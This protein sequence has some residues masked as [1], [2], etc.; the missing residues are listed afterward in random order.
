[1]PLHTHLHLPSTAQREGEGKEEGREA[2]WGRGNASATTYHKHTPHTTSPTHHLIHHPP[3][4]CDFSAGGHVSIHANMLLG[5]RGCLTHHYLGDKLLVQMYIALSFFFFGNFSSFSSLSLSHFFFLGA[6]GVFLEGVRCRCVSYLPSTSLPLIVVSISA[7]LQHAS[8]PPFLPGQFPTASTP[9]FGAPFL[10][11]DLISSFFGFQIQ[12][13]WGKGSSLFL[14]LCL[15]VYPLFHAT[16]HLCTWEVSLPP[17]PDFPVRHLESNPTVPSLGGKHCFP[18]LPHLSQTLPGCA[19]K[20][21]PCRLTHLPPQRSGRIVLHHVSLTHM[22]CTCCLLEASAGVQDLTLPPRQASLVGCCASFPDSDT[23]HLPP[24]PGCLNPRLPLPATRTAPPL[25]YLLTTE[26][27]REIISTPTFLHARARPTLPFFTARAHTHTTYPKPCVCD[28]YLEKREERFPRS[29]PTVNSLPTPHPTPPC[30]LPYLWQLA[31]LV[32]W[33][34][35]YIHPHC[36]PCWDFLAPPSFP[37]CS[38][39]LVQTVW[40][41]QFTTHKKGGGSRPLFSQAFKCHHL[42]CN[43]LQTA[44]GGLLPV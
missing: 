43:K 12:S 1:M 39:P 8:L 34:C 35:S 11:W 36:V 3:S 7:C 29:P 27:E 31:F 14:G 44:G 22:P 28:P 10:Q 20:E 25:L 17:F 32:N 37:T 42:L 21:K 19:M 30:A 15:C 2:E 33:V 41:V 24:H 18:H 38:G 4:V 23:S 40:V 26:K 13:D 5:G 6:W 16:A 9:G